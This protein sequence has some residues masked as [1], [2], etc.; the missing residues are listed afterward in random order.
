MLGSSGDESDSSR[1]LPT[2][3]EVPRRSQVF[4]SPDS[5]N[6]NNKETYRNVRSFIKCWEA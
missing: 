5:D 2:N 6:S 1:G 4:P 3:L